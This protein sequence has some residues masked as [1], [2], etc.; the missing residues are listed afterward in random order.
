MFVLY[1]RKKKREK[2]D[3]FLFTN[4]SRRKGNMTYF[5]QLEKLFYRRKARKLILHFN[6][7]FY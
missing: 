1:R 2:Q 4:F 6:I 5:I 7:G 3:F